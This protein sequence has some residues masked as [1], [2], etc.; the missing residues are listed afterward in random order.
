MTTPKDIVDGELEKLIEKRIKIAS[1]ETKSDDEVVQIAWLADGIDVWYQTNGERGN[2]PA[3]VRRYLISSITRLIAASRQK[4]LAEVLPE[5]KTNLFNPE[6][7]D[8]FCRKCNKGDG[9]NAAI[10]QMID[11]IKGIGGKS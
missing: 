11:N 2:S 5:K 7:C 3:A 8:M 10:D 9:F 1:T 6:T 4:W